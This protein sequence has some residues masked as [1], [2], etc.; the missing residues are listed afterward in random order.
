MAPSYQTD[1]IAGYRIQLGLALVAGG[2]LLLSWNST[3]DKMAKERQF[4]SLG[5]ATGRGASA[6]ISRRVG[7]Y[8]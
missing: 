2:G 8:F 1:S 3:P 6:N 4:L 7:E 5:G